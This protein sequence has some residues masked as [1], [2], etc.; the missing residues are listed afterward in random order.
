M[1]AVAT[2]VTPGVYA[3]RVQCVPGVESR[4]RE[5]P[6]IECVEPELMNGQVSVMRPD[7]S[8]MARASQVAHGVPASA[9]EG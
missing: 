9:C 2:S 7:R 3:R 4:Q 8:T 1:G 6:A 5:T